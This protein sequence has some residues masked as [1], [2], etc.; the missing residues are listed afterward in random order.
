MYKIVLATRYL[1][2]RRI[3]YFAVL[4]V[5][6]CVFIVVVVMTVLTGLVDNFRQKNHNYVGDCVVGTESLA[7]FAYYEDFTANLEKADFI[8]AVSP[9]IKSCALISRKNSEENYGADIIGLDP[10]KHNRTTNFS[11]T[12]PPANSDLVQQTLKDPYVFDFL[13]LEESAHEREIERAMMLHIRDTLV[14]MGIGFAFVGRQVRLE[15][16]GE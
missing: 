15:V 1:I 4:A 5:A 10:V 12:L 2:K 8:E 16:G 11:Q 13:G 7:G 6:L 9:V 14:E 3:T